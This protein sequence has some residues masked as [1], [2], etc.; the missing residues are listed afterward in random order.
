MCY[1]TFR[2]VKPISYSNFPYLD[3]FPSPNPTSLPVSIQPIE[4]PLDMPYWN[5]LCLWRIG[6]FVYI[7]SVSK[8]KIIQ[9]HIK[10]FDLLLVN[11]DNTVK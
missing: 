1:T 6:L 4:K 10:N 7:F 3:S 8:N 9:T 5:I 2:S 11:D